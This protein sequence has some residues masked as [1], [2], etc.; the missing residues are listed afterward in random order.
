MQDAKNSLV[1]QV[2]GTPERQTLMC[3]CLFLGLILE[4]QPEIRDENCF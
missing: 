1:L 4:E 2:V 3:F